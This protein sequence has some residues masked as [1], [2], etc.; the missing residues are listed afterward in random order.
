MRVCIRFLLLLKKNT[1]FPT[2]WYW[3]MAQKF[4]TL[5]AK[6]RKKHRFLITFFS[7]FWGFLIIFDQFCHGRQIFGHSRPAVLETLKIL[8]FELK[9]TFLSFFCHFLWF[10][11]NPVFCRGSGDFCHFLPF[12]W[13]ISRGGA[14][15]S[16]KWPSEPRQNTGQKCHFFRKSI[17]KTRFLRIPGGFWWFLVIFSDF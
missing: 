5:L 7:D 16:E 1:P 6:K 15:E 17:A 9:M 13:K 12:F 10:L 8:D 2:W 4:I 14:G 11:R 3:K